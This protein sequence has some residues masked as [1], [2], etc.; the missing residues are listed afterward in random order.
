MIVLKYQK[1]GGMKF[2]SHI[3]VLRNMELIVRRAEI[4][5]KF[6]EGFNPHPLLFFSPPSVLGIGSVSEYISINTELSP[7]E[8]LLRFNA[9]VT[10]DLKAVKAFYVEKEPK[11]QGK[12]VAADYVLDTSYEGINIKPMSKYIATFLVKGETVTDDIGN[13]I[14]DVFNSSGKL[15]LRLASGNNN[16]RPD[17]V[18]GQI[19]CD[20][21]RDLSLTDVLKTKQ[22]ILFEDEYLDVDV[23]L[24]NKIIGF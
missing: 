18:I 17:R 24:E 22:Y 16:L 13:K 14:F 4:P 19:N 3:D 20:F 21:Q 12:I 6:S 5:V 11:L 2:V 10:D 8:A 1:L 9:S 23:A 7:N 15:G